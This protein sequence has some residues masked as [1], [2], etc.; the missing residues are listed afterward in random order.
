MWW[1]SCNLI[2]RVNLKEITV[3]ELKHV[4][5]AWLN[6][7]IYKDQSSLL[8]NHVFFTAL[9]WSMRYIYICVI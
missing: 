8:F 5:D 6:M 3:H 9:E 2:N 7:T 4:M 1:A